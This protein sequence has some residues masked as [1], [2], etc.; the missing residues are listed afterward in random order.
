[1]MAKLLKWLKLLFLPCVFFGAIACVWLL[2]PS[3]S[4][5][6]HIKIRNFPRPGLSS[7]LDQKFQRDF[8]AWLA[9]RLPALKYLLY[10]KNDTYAWLNLGLFYNSSGTPVDRGEDGVLYERGYLGAHFARP[11]A[12][13]LEKFSSAAAETL[14]ALNEELAERGIRLLLVIAP[15]KVDC[16][17]D[18]VPWLWKFRYKKNPENM[19]YAHE[20][21][22]RKL[23]QAGV[24]YVNC[25]REILD[26]GECDRA[27]TDPGTHWSLYGAGLCLRKAANTLHRL[28]PREFPDLKISGAVVIHEAENHERDIAD[29]LNLYP[30]YKK[31]RREFWA[32]E[33]APPA[34]S[35]GATIHGDSFSNQFRAVLIGSGYGKPEEM[36][37]FANRIPEKDEFLSALARSKALILVETGP[38]FILPFLDGYEKPLVE[39]LRQAKGQLDGGDPA[40]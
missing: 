32:A 26:R 33:F 9:N 7:F 8:E 16:R 20:Y 27:F 37:Q 39:Y 40:K 25:L 29:L 19:L 22:E 1:M 24:P 2:R 5:Y 15:D 18:T 21:F 17:P 23:R 11:G 36:F 4:P 3:S 10:I 6:G 12:D 31:G 34:A 38:K 13:E 30:A 35:V 28:W 14:A